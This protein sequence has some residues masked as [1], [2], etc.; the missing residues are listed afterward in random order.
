MPI[1]GQKSRCIKPCL[2]QVIDNNW[3]RGWPLHR[4]EDV[5]VW[6]VTPTVHVLLLVVASQRRER[7][8]RKSLCRRRTRWSRRMEFEVGAPGG[9]LIR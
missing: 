9:V 2:A 4:W 1:V 8:R 5:S 7:E 3:C 6:R